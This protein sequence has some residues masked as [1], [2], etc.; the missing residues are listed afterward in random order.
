MI[1]KELDMKK[2]T[3]EERKKFRGPAKEAAR[4]VFGVDPFDDEILDMEIF[5]ESNQEGNTL[6]V[7]RQYTLGIRRP[8]SMIICTDDQLAV[9]RS[10]SVS[11]VVAEVSADTSEDVLQSNYEMVP[12]L[13]GEINCFFTET[14]IHSL[15]PVEDWP[16]ECYIEATR[17][18]NWSD[19]EYYYVI[20]PDSAVNVITKKQT[21]TANRGVS[22][23]RS[24]VFVPANMNVSEVCLRKKKIKKTGK[25]VFFIFCPKYFFAFHP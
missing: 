19:Y 4:E 25:T 24:T 7:L 22:G 8:V 3:A 2:L 17:Y 14:G 12:L 21:F 15:D 20:T 13:L 1:T 11:T 6:P 5:P 9:L 16:T 18:Y 23:T 10:L